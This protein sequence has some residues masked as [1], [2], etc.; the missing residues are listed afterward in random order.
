MDILPEGLVLDGGDVPGRRYRQGEHGLAKIPSRDGLPQ[1]WRPETGAAD[2]GCGV[3]DGSEPARG[4]G[5]TT[6]VWD[7]A[8]LESSLSGP[9]EA[10]P[11]KGF[12]PTPPLPTRAVVAR[13]ALIWRPGTPAM[14][15]L[16][17]CFLRASALGGALK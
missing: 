15:S 9:V 11:S 17:G 16:S 7:C 14:R 13:L 5:G 2:A 10:K 1:S 3:K 6:G 12:S 4:A 8:E